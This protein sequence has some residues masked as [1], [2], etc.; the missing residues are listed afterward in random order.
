VSYW[1]RGGHFRNQDEAIGAFK[2][3]YQQGLDGMGPSIQ[4]WM[5]LT[6][7][8]FDAWMRDDALPAQAGLEVSDAAAAAPTSAAAVSGYIAWLVQ[9][10]QGEFEYVMRKAGHGAKAYISE[11]WEEFRSNK[12]QFAWNWHEELFAYYSSIADIVTTRR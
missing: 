7:P 6:G 9:L 2:L 3:A 1:Y 8:E 4:Q 11:K 10:N 12:M 5:G